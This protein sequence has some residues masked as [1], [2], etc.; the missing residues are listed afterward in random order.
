MTT[1]IPEPV[2][3]WREGADSPAGT[4]SD[5]IGSLA[6]ALDRL[7]EELAA[8]QRALESGQM[9]NLT[10]LDPRMERLCAAVLDA[11]PSARSL[12]PQL[13]RLIS[14]LDG[15]ETLLRLRHQAARCLAE[16]S[17]PSGEDHASALKRANRAYGKTPSDG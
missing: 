13:G 11:R 6:Q 2:G 14:R 17:V 1:P 9:V 8:A 10:G 16:A 12:L 5:D 4:Q 15:L 3:G 7:D